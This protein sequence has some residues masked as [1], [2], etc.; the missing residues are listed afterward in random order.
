MPATGTASVVDAAA[1]ADSA[2]STGPEDRVHAATA[3]ARRDRAFIVSEV[4]LLEPKSTAPESQASGGGSAYRSS[5]ENLTAKSSLPRQIGLV[6][7][8]KR[9]KMMKAS[10]RA[11]LLHIHSFKN[12]INRPPRSVIVVVKAPKRQGEHSPS[13]SLAF[14]FYCFAV[15]HL[16]W[17]LLSLS[18]EVED[19]RHG[20]FHHLKTQHIL[21]ALTHLPSQ[22]N[23]SLIY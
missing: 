1:A 4:V 10:A 2:A 19:T 20:S 12:S 11:R 7:L 17:Y 3:E 21:L 13:K 5:P 9:E 16:R 18:E 23:T 14:E 8:S 22:P 15:R 6:N